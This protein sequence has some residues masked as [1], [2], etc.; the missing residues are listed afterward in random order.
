MRKEFSY[1]RFSKFWGS[2]HWLYGSEGW[3]YEVDIVFRFKN[4]NL[5]YSSNFLDCNEVS[6]W[7]NLA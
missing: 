6:V 5:N 3:M 4:L 1:C 2:M 7:K